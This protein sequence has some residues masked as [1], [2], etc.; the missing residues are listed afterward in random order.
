[1]AVWGTPGD[2]TSVTSAPNCQV[3]DSLLQVHLHSNTHIWSQALVSDLKNDVAGQNES[4]LSDDCCSPAMLRLKVMYLL[5]FLVSYLHE[6]RSSRL[7]QLGL[8]LAPVLVVE[9]G[10]KNHYGAA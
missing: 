1:M 8:L 10:I 6:C 5:I 9:R 4:P 3:S 2:K 7:V